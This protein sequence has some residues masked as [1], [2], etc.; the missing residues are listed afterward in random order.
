MVVPSEHP[1]QPARDDAPAADYLSELIDT[2][3]GFISQM[4]ATREELIR[5]IPVF[6]FLQEAPRL[7]LCGRMRSLYQ[8][9]RISRELDEFWSHSWRAPMWK[10]YVTVLLL[11]NVIPALVVGMLS[12]FLGALGFLTG[13]LPR[14]E[15]GSHHEC[16]WCTLLGNAAYYLTLLLFPRRRMVFLDHACVMQSDQALKAETVVSMGG[17]LKSCKSMLV[18]WDR[19]YVTRLWCMFEL[20]AFLHIRNEQSR[21]LAICPIHLGPVVFGGQLGLTVMVLAAVFWKEN[22]WVIDYRIPTGVCLILCFTAVAHVMRASWRDIDVMKQQLSEFRI[23]HTRSQCCETKPAHPLVC[24]RDILL[25]CITVWFGSIEK[26]ELRVRREVQD[27]L[28]RQLMKEAFSYSRLVQLNAP[29]LWFFL[30]RSFTYETAD[31]RIAGAVQAFTHWL[32]IGPASA[33]IGLWIV[34]HLR[35]RYCKGCLDILVSVIAVLIFAVVLALTAS[36][37]NDVV[38]GYTPNRLSGSLLYLGISAVVATVLFQC[39]PFLQRPMV[40]RQAPDL[41]HNYSPDMAER[42]GSDPACRS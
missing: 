11:N 19:T 9:S 28:L 2:S 29:V 27:A 24:D 40:Q 34:L 8:Y 38:Y 15:D 10:K 26:F 6:R 23:E 5:G 41:G 36:L 16:R 32:V 1:P 20:S 18:L 4:R 21:D 30:D 33:Q 37:E 3:V 7:A 31:E 39:S 25:R 42:I 14:W 17:I 22:T 12:A 35:S 13:V